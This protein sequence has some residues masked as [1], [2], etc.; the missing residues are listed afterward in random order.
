[1]SEHEGL[2][3]AVR[4]DERAVREAL[5]IAGLLGA[6]AFAGWYVMAVRDKVHAE[7]QALGLRGANE[8]V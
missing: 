1:M 2:R 4:G 7:Y 5:H 8:H 6:T 3:R